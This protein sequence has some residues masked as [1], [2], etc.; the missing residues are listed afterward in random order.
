MTRMTDR[1]GNTSLD[2]I[3]RT[4]V[5]QQDGYPFSSKS[6]AVPWSHILGGHYSMHAWDDA[7]DESSMLH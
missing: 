4:D 1:I 7:M 6:M 3:G 5:N 2:R